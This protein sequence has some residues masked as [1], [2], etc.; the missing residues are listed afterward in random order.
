MRLVEAIGPA[1]TRDLLFTGRLLDATEAV[2][3]GLA[4]RLTAVDALD[5]AVRELAQTIADN[6][7]LTIRAAKKAIHRIAHRRRLEDH[8]ADDLTTLCY[9]S[10]DFREGVAAFLEKRKPRFTGR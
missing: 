7:P 8:F 3:V 1:R 4:T 10:Q 2:S 9:G 6:A 5:A